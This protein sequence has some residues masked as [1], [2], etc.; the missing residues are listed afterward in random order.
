MS[1]VTPYIENLERIKSD[2]ENVA[3]QSII[4]NSEVIIEV[5]QNKQLRLGIGS[6][7][8]VVAKN[9]KKITETYWRFKDPP[10]D[11]GYKVTTNKYDFFWSG[12]WFNQMY[13]LVSQEEYS[14]FSRDGK[15]QLLE[16]LHGPLLKLTKENNDD[17]N[18]I[19]IKRSLGKFI[20]SNLFKV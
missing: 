16:S 20:L 2:L 14:I 15:T 13:L 8:S 5:L 6:N 11:P 17:I 12:S 3:K 19:V 7:G 10:V 9:Y 1:V 4:D 18:E